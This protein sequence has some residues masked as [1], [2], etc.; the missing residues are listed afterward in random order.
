[1]TQRT[2]QERC[3]DI[4]QEFDQ[5]LAVRVLRHELKWEDYPNSTTPSATTSLE[6]AP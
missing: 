4:L 6:R 3:L 5:W 1:M 2:V